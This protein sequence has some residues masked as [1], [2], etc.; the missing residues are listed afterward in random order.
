MTKFRPGD[1]LMAD[2]APDRRIASAT[3]VPPAS[4]ENYDAPPGHVENGF[5]WSPEDLAGLQANLAALGVAPA[6]IASRDDIRV[7]PLA[8]ATRPARRNKRGAK[9]VDLMPAQSVWRKMINLPDGQVVAAAD[10][11]QLTARDYSD[12]GL[13]YLV[14]RVRDDGDDGGKPK[15]P[16]RVV[17]HPLGIPRVL[18]LLSPEKYEPGCSDENVRLTIEW[19]IR[20]QFGRHTV[21]LKD[22]NSGTYLALFGAPPISTKAEI[23]RYANV[24]KGQ[25]EHHLQHQETGFRIK[26]I[27][28]HSGWSHDPEGCPRFVL[29]D[30]SESYRL[31]QDG[32][33]VHDGKLS[34]MVPTVEDFAYLVNAWARWSPDG[35]GVATHAFAIRGLFA[36]LKRT[37]TSLVITGAAGRTAA[38]GSSKSTPA[39]SALGLMRAVKQD[40]PLTLT[41]TASA[42]AMKAK[43]G[44]RNDLPSVHDD[45]HKMASEGSYARALDTF[46]SVLRAI[47]D[48][49][50]LN[51]RATRT[52][53]LREPVHLLGADIFTGEEIDGLLASAERRMAWI[54]YSKDVNSDAIYDEWDVLQ[55]IWEGVGHAVIRWAFPIFAAPGGRDKLADLIASLD[56]QM[57]EAIFDRLTELRPQAP[58]KF[59]RSMARNWAPIM[60]GAWLGDRAVGAAEGDGPL[61]ETLRQTIVGL[62]LRQLDRL[63]DGC[64]AA[65]LN[66]EWFRSAI[67][68][69]LHGHAYLFG[70]NDRPLPQACPVIADCGY[71]LRPG[72]GGSTWEPAGQVKLGWLDDDCATQL[73]DPKSLFEICRKAYVRANPRTPFP[74]AERSLAA[75][76]VKLGVAAPEQGGRNVQRRSI[77]DEANRKRVLVI[78]AIDDDENSGPIGP[79][80]PETRSYNDINALSS[81]I[82]GP[83]VFGIGPIGPTNSPRTDNRTD[84]T[85]GYSSIGPTA[86]DLKA[87]ERLGFCGDRTDRTD[88]TDHFDA[89]KTP[90]NR[91]SQTATSSKRDTDKVPAATMAPP[92]RVFTSAEARKAEEWRAAKA[93]TGPVAPSAPPRP[94]EGPLVPPAGPPA[95]SAAGGPPRAQGSPSRPPAGRQPPVATEPVP[96]PGARPAPGPSDGS[97]PQAAAEAPAGQAPQAP[98]ERW[99]ERIAALDQEALYILRPDG[100]I[101]RQ[102]LAK[103]LYA[104]N[105]C[106]GRLAAFAVD[107]RITQLWLHPGYTAH[108]DLPAKISVTAARKGIECDFASDNG[109]PSGWRLMA[110]GKL[111]SWNRLANGRQEAYIVAPR[112]DSEVRLGTA[113]D[114]ATMLEAIAAFHAATRFWYRLDPAVTFDAMLRTLHRN[115]LDLTADMTPGEFPEPM[116]TEIVAEQCWCRGLTKQETQSGRFVHTFDK[117]GT[118]LATMSSLAVGFGTPDYAAMPT[119]E[120]RKTGYWRAR[121]TMP[122]TWPGN[123]PHPGDTR[124]RQNVAAMNWY[125]TPTLALAQQFGGKIE[126]SEAWLFNET[127]QPFAPVYR[128]LRDAREQLAGLGGPAAKLALAAVKSLYTKGLGNLASHSKREATEAIDLY[129]PDW[130]HAIVAMARANILRNTVKAGV[131]P[132]AIRTDAIHLISDSADPLVAGK[133]LRQGRELGQWK[134]IGTIPLD[135]LPVAFINGEATRSPQRHLDELKALTEQYHGS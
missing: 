31:G 124:P 23:S 47:A 36:T 134:H 87:A 58:H 131:E 3:S 107:E 128:R 33:P 98:Q 80:G 101:D 43:R 86:T 119:F 1:L 65:E 41:F 34:P 135:L 37:G 50:E 20:P 26:Q 70:A 44:W 28:S 105:A 123:L 117:H 92:R 72:M 61:V 75:T 40:A 24:L 35:K 84:R 102:P 2:Q 15:S 30:L 7:A 66:A 69:A 22:I 9:I 125:V 16:W 88:R 79:I 21:T 60:T 18:E 113:E 90:E 132:F 130:R 77:P 100:S 74:L 121:I 93:R 104:E 120:P 111:K 78:N 12:P 94:Q 129:R 89:S 82:A 25:I 133:G 112:L 67:W 76:L 71:Q 83:I 96:K 62:A 57:T 52:G 91:S 99:L 19:S 29:E 56:R 54:G 11:I 55:R 114:A 122:D 5:A 85:D 45:F 39:R 42:A 48:G 17:S 108:T 6:S 68:E 53:A 127:H 116:R 13:K 118:Y 109:V 4:A 46:D 115:G 97:A 27:P 51:A 110:P 8:D 49:D 126:V 14:H 10:L 32:R 59:I 95:P 106:S 63:T 103:E 81:E 73:L 64:V 38:T